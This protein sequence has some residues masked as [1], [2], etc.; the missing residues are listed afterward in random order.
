MCPCKEW[1]DTYNECDAS[2]VVM[3][4]DSSSKAIE[5]GTVKVKMF[6]GVVRALSN[7]KYVPK[8][9]SLISL[10]PLDILSYDFSTKNGIMDI[11]KGALIAMKRKR[12]KILY[13]LIRKTILGTTMKVKTCHE[14]SSRQNDQN[15]ILN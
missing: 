2:I 3:G 4:N 14:K 13:T 5:I 1:L 11:N 7:G 8:L 9:R 15:S 12:V 6:D 10:E